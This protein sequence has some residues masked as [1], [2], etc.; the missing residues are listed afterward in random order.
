MSDSVAA[1]LDDENFFTALQRLQQAF[2][3]KGK[4]LVTFMS[5]SSPRP[6]PSAGPLS[7]APRPGPSASGPPGPPGPGAR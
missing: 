6:G 7:R 5:D 1:R 4:D 2:A 3:I